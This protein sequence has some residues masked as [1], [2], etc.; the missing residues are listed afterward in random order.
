VLAHI[1]VGKRPRA[2]AWSRDGL[3]AFVT[4]ELDASVSVIDTRSHRAVQQIAL[5]QPTA[6]N[7]P[8]HRPMGIVRS[9]DGAE[10]ERKSALDDSEIQGLCQWAESSRGE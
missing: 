5:A 7:A 10:Q 8:T 6:A 3:Y 1:P 4:N 2:L 9:S